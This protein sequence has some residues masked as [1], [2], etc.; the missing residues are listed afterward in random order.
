MQLFYQP[1]IP[2]GTLFL[3]PEESGHCIRVLRKKGGDKITIT[4]G[5]GSIYTARILEAN[6][7]KCSFEILET[8]SLPPKGYN[9]H[10]AIAPTKNI[11]R[12]EWFV[13]KCTEIGI[14]R[15]SF[16]TGKYSE[17]KILKTERLR[18]KSIAAMKQSIKARMPI[19]S[20]LQKFEEMLNTVDDNTDRFIAYVDHSN[21]DSLFR[22]ASKGQNYCVLIGP[23]GDFSSE[24]LKIALSL[25]FRKVNLGNSRLRTETAGVVACHTLN[26]INS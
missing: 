19:I 13:E 17:R 1:G 2:D 4:D 14:D 18:K 21:N 22:L 15:I 3:E 16:F 6:S 20:E 25:G 12:I 9:I 7:K 23:E 5:L 24:E 26:L 8:E 10:I 11:D